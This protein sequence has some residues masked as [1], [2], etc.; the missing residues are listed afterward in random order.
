[1][2]FT[3]IDSQA[4]CAEILAKQIEDLLSKDQKVLWLLSGGSNLS[5]S[6]EALK[7][8]KERCNSVFFISARMSDKGNGV[9]AG[10]KENL[11]VILTDERYGLV[12]HP[13]SNWQQL[14]DAG[15]DMEAVTS[16]PILENI[17]LDETVERFSQKYE[18]LSKW[19]DVIVGQFGIGTDGHTA[20]V[21]P[22]TKGTADT[23]IACVGEIFKHNHSRQLKNFTRISLTLE[24][25]KKIN[26][27]FAFAFGASK[28][29][30]IQTLQ[31]ADLSLDQMPAQVL[32]L[33][34]ESYLYSD[35]V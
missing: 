16:H 5:I 2:K 11:A 23:G 27:A 13:D 21:L 26:I 30:V 6:V 17:S 29:D 18:A 19:A 34:P 7:I 14:I 9:E 32:K 28:K 1:M 15:F 3:H 33:I 10:L 12:G 35:Q 31:T 24:T 22:Q 20:G 4:D 25:I 8:L